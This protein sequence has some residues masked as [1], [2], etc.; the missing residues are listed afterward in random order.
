MRAC[1]EQ[2]Y[3]AKVFADCFISVTCFSDL[4]FALPDAIDSLASPRAC[5]VI[6]F[7]HHATRKRLF[8]PTGH[9][10]IEA[11]ATGRVCSIT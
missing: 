7:S 9:R 10:I 6:G 1:L 11:F 8:V 4:G 3:A 2:A 5:L